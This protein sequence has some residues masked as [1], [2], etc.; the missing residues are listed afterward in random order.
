MKFDISGKN[1]TTLVGISF[2]LGIKELTCRNNQLKSF[3]GLPQTVEIIWASNNQLT[4]F[5][6]LPQNLNTLDIIG[7]LFTSLVGCPYAIRYL[8]CG[9]NKLTSLIGCPKY[10]TTLWCYTNPITS[11]K[12]YPIALRDCNFVNTPIH[13]KY[14]HKEPREM[15]I[16][17]RKEYIVGFLLGIDKIRMLM[18]CIKIQRWWRKKWYD[19]VDE[20]G[21]TRFCK[22][23]I[24]DIS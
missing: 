2:P 19:E 5:E 24:K 8:Y 23:A 12:G 17:A 11:F 6:G 15:N 21:I 4:S 7:N 9:N 1:L 16:I 14:G 20:Q 18:Y 3:V 22:M 13:K 10:V